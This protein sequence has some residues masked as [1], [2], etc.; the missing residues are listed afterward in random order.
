MEWLRTV[1]DRIRRKNKI[2]FSETDMFLEDLASLIKEQ[3][4]RTL[5]LWAFEFADE[6]V[7]KMLK[8]YPDEKRLERAVLL[9]KDWAAGKVKMPVAK[10]AILQAH[11]V[12]KEIED[13]EDIALCHAVGQACGVVHTTG[14]ALGFPIYELTSIVRHYGLPECKEP[15]EA[16][17]KHYMER[18]CYWRENYGSFLYEWAGFMMKD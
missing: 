10:Q 12:A 3:N 6:I 17:K 15:V 18:L 8:R 16:R 4:H 2:L 11:G 14:H 5:V 13:V 1:E 9:S 7:Q